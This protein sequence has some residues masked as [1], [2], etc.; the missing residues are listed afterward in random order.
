MF[1]N[2][3]C[4]SL[5]GKHEELRQDWATAET[6]LQKVDTGDIP[7]LNYTKNLLSNLLSR[8]R[9]EDN[10]G[11]CE[12]K[13]SEGLQEV[14]MLPDPLRRPLGALF[15]SMPEAVAIESKYANMLCEPSEGLVRASHRLP[16]PLCVLAKKMVSDR[17][18]CE[19][20]VQGALDFAWGESTF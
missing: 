5:Q 10:N 3:L 18:A 15:C 9:P 4:D 19:A 16:D 11:T 2:N 20:Y 7:V 13:C 1:C 14:A 17:E 8:Y 6:V 12:K